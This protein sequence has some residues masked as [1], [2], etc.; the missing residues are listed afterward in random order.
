MKELSELEKITLRKDLLLIMDYVH[1]LCVKNN[2]KYS[3]FYGSLIGA[4]VHK[5]FIP[6]DDDIDIVFMKE[7]WN[8]FKRIFIEKN[9]SRFFLQC[10]ETEPNYK[11]PLQYKIRLNDTILL[12]GVDSH[13]NI[14]HGVSLDVVVFENID[15]KFLNLRKTKYYFSLL[16]DKY[17]YK[18]SIKEMS[19]KGKIYHTFRRCLPP[20]SISK[21][22]T[23][24][25]KYATKC[26]DNDS[27]FVFLPYSYQDDVYKREWLKSI[28]LYDFAG[29]QYYCFDDYDKILRVRYPNYE[30]IPPKSEQKT[31]H[32][33]IDIKL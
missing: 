1:D 23:K 29:R 8:H 5:G 33:Y 10:I 11:I 17:Y 25:V 27:K 32:Q 22:A 31:N 6:W 28:S 13:I 4:I 26:K 15:Q 19:L 30:I 21:T 12:E 2:I 3:L 18:G 24:F 20:F 16:R 14:H 7:E 9:D